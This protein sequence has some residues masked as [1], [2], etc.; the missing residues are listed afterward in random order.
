ML[1]RIFP[2]LKILPYESEDQGLQD[3][4]GKIISYIGTHFTQNLSQE[5]IANHFGIGKYAL[6]RIFSNVLHQSF[7]RYLNSLRIN[8]AKHL[9]TT[10]NYSITRIA[11]EY[12]YNNQQTFNR[13]FKEFTGKTPKEYRKN[14]RSASTPVLPNPNMYSE[15]II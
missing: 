9:L 11:I 8:Y 6:S 14:F 15:I 7:N 10:S 1:S 5:M 4:S 3:L 2:Y 13:V 12:A